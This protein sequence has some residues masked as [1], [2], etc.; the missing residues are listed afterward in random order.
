MST[1]SRCP[2]TLAYRTLNTGDKIHLDVYLPSEGRE[3]LNVPGLVY[4]HGG[5]LISG[6]RQSFMPH[7]LIGKSVTKVQYL[8]TADTIDLSQPVIF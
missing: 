6:N 3:A 7:G 4:F 5:G 1:K 2:I 8:G